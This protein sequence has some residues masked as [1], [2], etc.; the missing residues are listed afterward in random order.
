MLLV[1]VVF[2]CLLWNVACATMEKE[3][4]FR[5]TRIAFN[6][7]RIAIIPFFVC[8]L[9]CFDS[10]I[11]PKQDNAKSGSTEKK[12]K[13]VKEE[14][15]ERD[16]EH[17]RKNKLLTWDHKKTSLQNIM[18]TKFIS[19][20]TFESVRFHTPF[21]FSFFLVLDSKLLFGLFFFISFFSS[22]R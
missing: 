8:I 17:D 11:G 16:K 13:S 19:D 15:K 2:F 10:I 6:S 22:I 7:F 9:F 20:F 5:K 21:R 4:N 18:Y 3:S 14:E 12:E 1:V